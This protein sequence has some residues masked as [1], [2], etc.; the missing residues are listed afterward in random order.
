MNEAQTEK[1]DLAVGLP[2]YRAEIHDLIE[3]QE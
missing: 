3:S 2:L 1:M